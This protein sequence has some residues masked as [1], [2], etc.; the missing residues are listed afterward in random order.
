[1]ARLSHTSITAWPPRLG[2]VAVVR[3]Q[4]QS[5]RVTDTNKV[6]VRIG[7]VFVAVGVR[8]S[9]GNHRKSVQCRNR[10]QQLSNSDKSTRTGMPHGAAR[11]GGMAGRLANCWLSSCTATSTK[12]ARQHVQEDNMTDPSMI[13][14]DFSSFNE[15]VIITPTYGFGWYLTTPLSSSG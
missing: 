14:T 2:D 11:M 8:I 6:R 10:C 13:P 4:H 15:G 5:S 12:A 9:G 3:C 1:M 7:K